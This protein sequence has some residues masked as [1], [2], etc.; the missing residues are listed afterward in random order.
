MTDNYFPN[1]E[2]NQFSNAYAQKVDSF[3]QE[4][5]NDDYQEIVQRR[6]TEADK[7]DNIIEKEVQD[8]IEA[9]DGQNFIENIKEE[10]EDSKF[11]FLKIN[12]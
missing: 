9:F 12:I 5:C 2:K 4:L 7:G 8:E 1:N 10:E 3:A 6:I 11:K